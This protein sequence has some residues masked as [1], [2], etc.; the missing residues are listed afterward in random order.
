MD[1]T[2]MLTTAAAGA[3]SQPGL[4]WTNNSTVAPAVGTGDS[5][6]S[7]S[8]A[9]LVSGSKIYRST[10]GLNWTLYN[11]F[12]SLATSLLGV[13]Y[14]NSEFVVWA[15]SFVA[16]SSDGL[17]WTTKTA[18]PTTTI[19]VYGNGTN[20]VAMGFVSPYYYTY[21]SSDNGSTWTI[22]SSTFSGSQSRQMVWDGTKYVLTY[23]NKIYTSTDGLSWTL[24]Y[25]F[26]TNANYT[27]LSSIAYNGSVYF[28]VCVP[29]A[30]SQYW[31]GVTSSNGTTWT[32]LWS[33]Y[34]SISDSTPWIVDW[35]S[36]TSQFL[37][38]GAFGA[39]Y[40][41]TGTSSTLT[42]LFSAPTDPYGQPYYTALLGTF[43]YKTIKIGSYYT[44]P[45]TYTV[46]ATF[47]TRYS[48]TIWVSNGL[49]SYSL[50]N[51]T[52]GLPFD[53][54]KGYASLTFNNKYI[55]AGGPYVPN[56]NA[57]YYST[58]S[59]SWTGTG[60]FSG[61]NL[62]GMKFA[63]MCASDTR[64]VALFVVTHYYSG[65]SSNQGAVLY[66][67]DGITW[68]SAAAVGGD[69]VNPTICWTGSEFVYV[70]A[71]TGVYTSPDGATW[72]FTPFTF[73]SG[74]IWF[75][76]LAID[77]TYAYVYSHDGTAM[78]RTVLGNWTGWSSFT[79]VGLFG[80]VTK[81][82][83]ANGKFVAIGTNSV[84]ATYCVAYSTDGINFTT[85]DAKISTGT[86]I[87]WSGFMFVAVSATTGISTSP[88]GINWT[89]RTSTTAPYSVTYKSGKYVAPG[90]WGQTIT[91]S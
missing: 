37:V 78:Y 61:A 66:T 79:P 39:V 59:T 86:N 83:Y 36:S 17:T 35:D 69:S 89:L 22:G 12:P 14:V 31:N 62:G 90:A 71:F 30:S 3:G 5:A 4:T 15:T 87:Y 21:V 38:K 80:T 29:S 85:V 41:S 50:G 88:D 44:Y 16:V 34:S 33:S 60:A 10:D 64:A 8:V 82:I 54:N 53:L 18:P 56:G 27:P 63:S 19:Y 43:N 11:P 23:G 28:A 6:T 75:E 84:L 24:V 13:N 70:Y 55:V 48:Y 25:T 81:V 68:A 58:N 77:S 49:A 74:S 7:G 91:S 46:G 20:L 40:S 52:T 1:L 57:I 26:S 42:P 73:G 47:S 67:S 45:G 51:L 2:Q 76:A 32:S 72:T 65:F 9:V